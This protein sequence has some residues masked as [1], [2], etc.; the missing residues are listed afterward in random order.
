MQI[1]QIEPLHFR[2]YMREKALT[3]KVIKCFARFSAQNI[4]SQ[5]DFAQINS[6]ALLP[7]KA[8]KK[9]W[10]EKAATDIPDLDPSPKPRV[11]LVP[12]SYKESPLSMHNVR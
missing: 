10:K 12:K 2:Q 9:E 5:G 4:V 8:R 11:Y 1:K 7:S 6:M 3:T